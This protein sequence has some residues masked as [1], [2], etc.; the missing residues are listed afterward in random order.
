MTNSDQDFD[1]EERAEIGRLASRAVKIDRRSMLAK[2]GKLLAFA[3]PA[4]A[5]FALSDTALGAVGSGGETGGGGMM[6]MHSGW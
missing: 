4:L 5:T 3:L 6:M 1:V 2:G